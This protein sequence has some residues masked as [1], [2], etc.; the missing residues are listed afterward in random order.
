MVYDR[1]TART[2]RGGTRARLA[3]PAEGSQD[4]RVDRRRREVEVAKLRHIA[5]SVQDLDKSAKFFVEAFD[6]KII[7]TPSKY[8]CYVSDGQRWN[9][10]A[11]RGRGQATGLRQ[12]GAVLWYDA[13]RHVGRRPCDSAAS[14]RGCGPTYVTGR[15]TLDAEH[16]LRNQVPRPNGQRLRHHGAW[17]GRRNEVCRPGVAEPGSRGRGIS[18]S[19]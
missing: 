9:V 12:G 16:L 14:G 4:H 18:A 1:A 5:L 19:R 3:A 15:R 11:P 6:M 2:R 13:F 17:L 8:V 7:G 10:R